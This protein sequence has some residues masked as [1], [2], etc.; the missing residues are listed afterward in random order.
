MQTNRS[1]DQ[2]IFLAI[3]EVRIIFIGMPALY[4]A[5]ASVGNGFLLSVCKVQLQV[6]AVFSTEADKALALLDGID[7]G[8]AT[9][10]QMTRVLSYTGKW[11]RWPFAGLLVCLGGLGVFL[12]RTGGLVRKFGMKTLLENNAEVFPCLTPV[13]GRGDYLLSRTS[14][15]SGPWMLARSPL[16]FAAVHGILTDAQGQAWDE[17]DLLR[18]GLGDTDLPAYGRAKFDTRKAFSVFVAQLGIPHR[19]FSEMPLPRR[20]MAAALVAYAAGA[21]EEGISL[22]DKVSASYTEQEGKAPRCAVLENS[23]FLEGLGKLF[24]QHSHVAG[25]LAHGFE[26]TW[27]M[28]LLTLARKKG[29]LAC[30]QFLWLRPLDRPLW[31]A[32]NQV[33]GRVAWSEAS[34]AWSH[35]QVEIQTGKALGEAFVENAV[36][37][38]YDDLA[39]QGWLSRK[40]D[41]LRPPDAATD[42]TN[43]PARQAPEVEEFMEPSLEPTPEF[44]EETD[45]EY[46][47][48]LSQEGV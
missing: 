48:K 20:A 11:V 18:E 9:W 46:Y 8:S 7:P 2:E 36:L 32:L 12:G 15:D 34:A 23:E 31:Y 25:S 38:L 33:G 13:V 21:K 42:K 30:S 14:Y 45:E 47:A 40:K 28:G 3:G 5:K 43:P 26:L 37:A 16:Q 22:L 35:Y 41:T 44:P 27:F 24:T 19:S 6:F 10:D 39:A 1:S 17:A 29:V 4:A